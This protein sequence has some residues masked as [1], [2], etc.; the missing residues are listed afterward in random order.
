MDKNLGGMKQ[1]AINRPEQLID[2][3]INKI[4]FM[5]RPKD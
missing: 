2:F 4:E 1:D 5:S 3:V